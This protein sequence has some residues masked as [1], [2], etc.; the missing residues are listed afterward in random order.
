MKFRV[1]L[2]PTDY[3]YLQIYEYG[4]T[5]EPFLDEKE[6]NADFSDL[7]G[8]TYTSVFDQQYY[9]YCQQK[10]QKYLPR[11][12]KSDERFILQGG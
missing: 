4:D 12:N 7:K 10:Y 5:C 1:K 2:L 3:G 9:Q 11:F 8:P 6:D